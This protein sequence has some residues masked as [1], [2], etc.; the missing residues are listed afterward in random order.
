MC[1]QRHLFIKANRWEVRQHF[2]CSLKAPSRNP[3]NYSS[4]RHREYDGLKRLQGRTRRVLMTFPSWME[5]SLEGLIPGCNRLQICGCFAL[6][7]RSKPWILLMCQWIRCN[8][9]PAIHPIRICPCFSHISQS[10][11]FLSMECPRELVEQEVAGTHSLAA[12]GRCSSDK[13]HFSPSMA[14]QLS[15]CSFMC[16]DVGVKVN[17]PK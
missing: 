7:F 14:S 8:S 17:S 5:A 16:P 1:R 3:R 10:C 13:S 4:D 15:G 6:F 12:G 11:W 9:K 2:R